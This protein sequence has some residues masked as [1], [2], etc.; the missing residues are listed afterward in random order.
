MK[1]ILHLFLFLMAF[2]MEVRV[3][4]SEGA[5]SL[6]EN[7][8]GKT[9]PCSFKVTQE[10]WSH[11]SDN[12]KLRALSRSMLTEEVKGKEWRVIDGTLWV[13]NAP[14]VKVRT[15]NADAEASNGQYWVL[16]EDDRV[17]F[18]NISSK[19]TITFK[20]QSKMEIPRGFEIWVGA[21]N[22]EARVEHGMVEPIN[23]KKHLKVWNELYPGS[24]E[25]FVTEVQDLRDQWSDLVEES[26][27]IYKKVAEKR[28]LA[29]DAEKRR[30][31]EL[32]KQKEQE[33]RV[34]RESFH[35]RVF[36]Y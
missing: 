10:K 20:D 25:Q 4:A 15:T 30:E 31:Q 32:R 24:K 3:R 17:I 8:L 26:G 23:L 22:S 35:R 21:V 29:L 18:R 14:S 1:K 27:D 7:C 36:E 33:R 34:L 9:V 5:L 6:P 19:L 28:M 16:V 12:I 13:E 11:Q 2:Q